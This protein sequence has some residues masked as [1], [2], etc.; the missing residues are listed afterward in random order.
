MISAADAPG[1]D[2][3][4]VARNSKDLLPGQKDPRF[5][6]ALL[7]AISLVNYIDRG[8]LAAVL[9]NLQ[10]DLCLSTSEAGWVASAFMAGYI[11]AAPFFANISGRPIFAGKGFRLM[12]IGLVSFCAGSILSLFSVWLGPAGYWP[13]LFARAVV[14]VGEAAFLV[15]A[16]PFLNS[17]APANSK[18]LYLALF[19]STIMLG[20]GVGYIVGGPLGG[21]G[22][23]KWIFVLD[24][25]L[26]MPFAIVSL[27]A[28]SSWETRR[29][30]A[31]EDDSTTAPKTQ[32]NEK[33]WEPPLRLLRQPAYCCLA[34]GY[35][36]MTATLGGFQIYAPQFLEYVYLMAQVG[37]HMS[38]VAHSTV[39]H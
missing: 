32:S 34:V 22:L 16:P 14:G 27:S 6:L 4:L 18:G 11:V 3:P 30:L 1:S 17:V 29:R 25:L 35:G 8:N 24:A 37:V 20:I 36:C 31:G 7:M 38:Q 28:P 9:T 10:A 13:L 21:H 15:L 5:F 12:G 39:G 19:Y 23:Y 2:Q 33:F 26:M